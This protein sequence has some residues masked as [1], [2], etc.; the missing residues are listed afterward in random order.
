MQVFIVEDH[1]LVREAMAEW[2]GNQ[3]DVQVVGTAPSAEETVSA[4]EH[5]SPDV[6]LLD[7]HL[8]G[9]SGIEC[10]PDILQVRPHAKVVLLTGDTDEAVL[11]DAITAGA[12]GF[13]LKTAHP[14]QVLRA[15]REAVA[16][17]FALDPSVAATVARWAALSSRPTKRPGDVPLSSRER[18][19]AQ[20]ASQGLTN[21]QIADR[22][23]ISPET[24]KTHLRSVFRK[25]GV[26][27]RRELRAWMRGQ[28]PRNPL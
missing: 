13:I 10:I 6:V 8:P 2:L 14:E 25:L 15:L 20:L 21:K 11:H 18:E 1:A 16:G 24:V 19:I 28:L 26:V 23:F 4:L 9:V 17:N 12:S 3:P 7:V 22:L 27:N 5:V